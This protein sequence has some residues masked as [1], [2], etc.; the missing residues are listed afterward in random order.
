V[1]ASIRQT[2]L[3]EKHHLWIRAGHQD[4]KENVEISCRISAHLLIKG[5]ASGHRSA[6]LPA[7]KVE[8]EKFEKSH[9]WIK[10]WAPGYKSVGMSGGAYTVDEGLLPHSLMYHHACSINPS[11]SFKLP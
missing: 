10:G 9:L 5:G 2:T 4:T 7:T 3:R 1:A 6:E 11:P 8:G